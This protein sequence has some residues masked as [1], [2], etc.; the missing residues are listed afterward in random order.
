M[1]ESKKGLILLFI[2]FF[3]MVLLSYLE[4]KKTVNDNNLI[5]EFSSICAHNSDSKMEDYCKN[6]DV[7]NLPSTP[8]NLT[9]FY[10]I[11]QSE[12]LYNLPLFAP[13]LLLVFSTY[14][15][16]RI[17]KSKYTYYYVQ[18]KKY[19]DLIKSVIINSYKYVLIVPFI[20]AFSYLLSL[21]ISS[22]GPNS[23]TEIMRIATFEK[24]HY[25][26]K[27]FIVLYGLN[28]M[29]IWLS[30]INIAL[31]IQ[32]K[33]RKF[34]FNIVEFIIV[35]FLLEMIL[36]NLPYNY[37]LF[38]IYNLSNISIYN[39]LLSSLIYFIISFIIL[40]LSYKNKEKILNRMGV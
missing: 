36:E 15:L 22:H 6:I 38:G 31:I 40:L 17:M 20:I 21:S 11:M 3:I 18:R 4:V 9:I 2:I 7:S 1:K 37:W 28:I 27:F 14:T 5:E 10:S 29:L 13:I 23:L 33:N 16:N 25:N 34:I 12:I 19:Y 39:Y 8:D 35:Y 30:F 26:T 32:S 24:I